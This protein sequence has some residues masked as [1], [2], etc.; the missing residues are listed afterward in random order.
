VRNIAHRKTPKTM[1]ELWKKHPDLMVMVSNKGRIAIR[2]LISGW[3][4]ARRNVNVNCVKVM[5]K[6]GK[7]VSRATDRLAEE[8]EGPFKDITGKIEIAEVREKEECEQPPEHMPTETI[9]S[10]VVQSC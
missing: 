10:N 7:W 2:S 5:Q 3:R 9:E 1:K 4:I 6:D 8:C